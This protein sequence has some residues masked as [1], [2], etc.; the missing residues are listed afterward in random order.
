MTYEQATERFEKASRKLDQINRDA[1]Y[2]SECGG[3]EDIQAEALKE[4]D[5]AWD[6]M[7][8]FEN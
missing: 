8:E 7:Q 3:F 4:Y 2:Y 6:L 1:H 5:D